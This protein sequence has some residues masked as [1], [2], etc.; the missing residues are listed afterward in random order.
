MTPPISSDDTSAH[1]SAVDIP[2][3]PLDR[4]VWP[5]VMGVIRDLLPGDIEVAETEEVLEFGHFATGICISMRLADPSLLVTPVRDLVDPGRTADLMAE[6]VGRIEY[7]VGRPLERLDVAAGVGLSLDHAYVVVG[8][9][10]HR[11]TSL[12]PVMLSA[13][14]SHDRRSAE[15][16]G[17]GWRRRG[18]R[19][20]D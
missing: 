11:P 16:S 2:P 13:L 10:G 9:G 8:E 7:V 1:A 17:R 5:S 3:P 19:R 14:P 12:R 15:P 6:V 4:T 18:R 20:T